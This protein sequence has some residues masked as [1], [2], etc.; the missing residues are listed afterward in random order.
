LDHARH[1]EGYHIWLRTPP[2]IGAA[3]LAS[4]LRPTGL[5][6]VPGESFLVDRAGASPFVR[7]SIGGA[8]GHERLKHAFETLLTI[9][10]HRTSRPSMLSGRRAV[11]P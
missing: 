6:A 4:A 1:P 5:S 11:S 3:E 9:L 2:V 7:L 10:D 8:I